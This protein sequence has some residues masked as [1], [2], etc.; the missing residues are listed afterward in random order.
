MTKKEILAL[1]SI[2]SEPKPIVIVSHKNPDGDAIGSSL[3]LANYLRQKNHD[4]TVIMPNDFPEFLKW[5]P[6]SSSVLFYDKQQSVCDEKIEDAK[7]IFT[8]DFN[9]LSRVQS[10]ESVLRKSQATFVMIDHHQEPDAYAQYVYSDP[11]ICATAQM[12]Y[13]FFE[14][15]QDTHLINKEIAENLYTGIMTDTGSFRFSSTTSVTHRVAAELIDKGIDNA[16]IHQAV[17]DVN[18]PERMQMLGVALQNLKILPEFKTAYITLSQEELDKHRHKKGDTEG[19]V[20]Y[21]LS[22]KD[23]V[24]AI[25]FIEDKEE[26]I[27]K[28]SLRSTGD[29][30]VNEFAKKH[31]NGGGHTNAAGGRSERTLDETV[32]YFIRTLQDYKNELSNT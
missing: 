31:F 18:S 32:S 14:M 1:Q 25:I 13:H 12:V 20:N 16:Q 19:F 21:A 24:F 7:V 10:M 6:G 29:F 2:L 5:L 3:A 17:F 28:M 26:G 9:A 8:L 15:M 11:T 4:V 23:V 22:V 30:S 27:I